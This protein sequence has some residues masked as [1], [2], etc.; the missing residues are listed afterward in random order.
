M[1]IARRPETAFP[2]MMVIERV[3]RR[4]EHVA[5][6]VIKHLIR[7]CPYALPVYPER[8]QGESLKD[9]KLNKLK[10]KERLDTE[11]GAAAL[12]YFCPTYM[13]GLTC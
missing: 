13:Y 8:A 3:S 4:Y 2:Y 12:M 7:V 11:E 1:Q 5:D 9:Y 10:Y 6:V